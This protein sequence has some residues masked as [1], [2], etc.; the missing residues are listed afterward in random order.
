MFTI[1]GEFHL[2]FVLD[3]SYMPRKEGGRGWIFTGDSV[4][5]AIRVLEKYIHSNDE[6]RMQAAWRDKI[7]GL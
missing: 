1:C 7:D 6:R 3:S 2:K 4:E 5:L